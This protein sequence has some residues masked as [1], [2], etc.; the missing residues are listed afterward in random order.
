[1][2]AVSTQARS[3]EHQF[4]IECPREVTLKIPKLP[5]QTFETAIIER[6]SR[7]EAS[8]EEPLVDIYLPEIQYF[9]SSLSSKRI[10]Q[11]VSHQGKSVNLTST[12]I[13]KPVASAPLRVSPLMCIMIILFSNVAGLAK[14]RMS[15]C[16]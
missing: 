9:A 13:S 14:T 3:D 8:I 12:S 16:L 4:H 10:R 6:Y 11:G 7:R 15:L 1:M 5:K 2:N